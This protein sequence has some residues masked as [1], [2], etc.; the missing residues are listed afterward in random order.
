LFFFTIAILEVMG[1]QGQ[2]GDPWD[3][4]CLMKT[5]GTGKCEE[6]IASLPA[7]EIDGSGAGL[8]DV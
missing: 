6:G 8:R 4:E 2:V 3:C 1:V 5:T 7:C